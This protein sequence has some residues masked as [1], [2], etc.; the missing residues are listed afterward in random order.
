MIRKEGKVYIKGYVYIS[1]KV[2]DF[3][4]DN[5]IFPPYAGDGRYDSF[6]L[7]E[8]LFE[9]LKYSPG[10]EDDNPYYPGELKLK[11]E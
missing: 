6:W 7:P 1:Q 3:L 10:Y 11:E 9:K 4:E 8:K 2:I 5:G